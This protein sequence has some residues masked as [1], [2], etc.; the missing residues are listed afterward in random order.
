MGKFEKYINIISFY[1]NSIAGVGLIAMAALAVLDI[2]GNKAFKYPLPGGIEVVG[3]LGVVVTAFAIAQTQILRGHIEV[4]FII[5]R[6]PRKL[7]KAIY[8]FNYVCLVVL[9]LVIAWRMIDYAL[10]LQNTGEVS[11]TE[12]IPFYPFVYCLAFC[13]ILTFLVFVTQLAKEI[14]GA[15]KK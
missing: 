4:E 2:I 13:C 11:M 1:L 5:E 3:F 15:R 12:R 14:T 10:I 6:F 7:Q 8:I 9:W